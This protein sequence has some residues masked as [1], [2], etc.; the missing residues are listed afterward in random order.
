MAD[1]R[2]GGG[3]PPARSPGCASATPFVLQQALF[4]RRAAAPPAGCCAG[5]TPTRPRCARPR[6]PAQAA[7]AW[8]RSSRAAEPALAA[9]PGAGA[10]ARGV[11]GD[12]V[13]VISPAGRDDRG[14]PRAQ[15]APLPGGAATSRSGMYEY[16]SVAR[17][18]LARRRPGVRGAG[19]PASPASRS[20]ST[21]RSRPRRVGRAVAVG[22]ARAALLDPRLDGDE[23]EP[24]RRAP[25]R[26]ARAVRD[27]H[28]HRAA[29]RRSRSSATWSC[30]WP[31]SA[32]RSASSRRWAP[33]RG[34]ITLVFLAA[35]M[36]IGAGRAPWR[37]AP[38]GSP[39]IWVQNT[40]KIIRLAGRRLPDRLPAD[41]AAPA[42][43]SLMIV[44]ATLV[45]LLPRHDLSPVAARRALDPV[46][47]SAMS[48]AAGP[49]ARRRGA[50]EGVPHRA[51][52]RAR[53]PRGRASP[54]TRASSSR[55]IGASGVGKSTLL[56]L[57]GAL[58]RPTARAGAVP[59]ARTSSR[60]P[61]SGAGPLP[62]DGGRLRLPVLQPARRDD[63]ARERDAPGAASSGARGGGAR[64]GGGGA[65]ARSGLG[66]RHGHRPGELSGGEQQRVAIARALVG[67]PRVILADEPT[68]N[69][70]PKTS[71]VICD[72]FL[73]LQAERGAGVRHR[74]PQSRAGAAGRPRRT[75]WWTA[76]RVEA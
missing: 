64:A 69:L 35:G 71:E 4:T 13:T 5:S 58:D 23:P 74:H 25:A 32:R 1:G 55:V 49:A 14:G 59:T 76:A 51:G 43:T 28:D 21:T 33:P 45:D 57:L 67:R 40:Y 73:R 39:S 18:H 56:H 75:G 31:R 47:C 2:R 53:A 12:T 34:S 52:A 37:A 65:R 6:S 48:D 7:A 61:E 42:P 29:S 16:D 9:R 38:S 3:P 54:C 30:W 68:G 70:D 22:A 20:S 44:G 11:P 15:D 50:R 41:E 27:R 17:L 19:R 26:E 60:G 8:S 46:E 72:L 63:R 24:L 62:A 66:D 36:L 10:H